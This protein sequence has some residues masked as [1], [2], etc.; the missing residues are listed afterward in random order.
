[1]SSQ[2]AQTKAQALNMKLEGS[3]REVLDEIDKHHLRKV[4]RAAFA[5]AVACYDK[6]GTTGPAEALDQCTA[7]CQLPHR[8][9]QQYVQQVRC[10]VCVNVNK[11]KDT[12][13]RD[14][15]S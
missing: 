12:R 6:A 3:A 7:N 10:V 13:K 2:A 14:V 4:A 1:M 9:K 15:T 8:Q 11:K 5:C